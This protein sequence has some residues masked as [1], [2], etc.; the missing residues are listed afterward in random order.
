MD[1]ARCAARGR[2]AR[3]LRPPA[4]PRSARTAATR[5]HCRAGTRGP[6]EYGEMRRVRLRPH[7]R[8]SPM[9]AHENLRAAQRLVG[10]VVPNPTFDDRRTCCEHRRSPFRHQAP[11]H[12]H[13]PPRWTGGDRAEHR[14]R[15]HHLD[16]GHER[17]SSAR[18]VGQIRSCPSAWSRRHWHRYRRLSRIRGMRYSSANSS[19]K[20]PRPPLERC[21]GNSAEP[22][23]GR[24]VLAA[25]GDGATVDLADAHHTGRRQEANQLPVLILAQSGQCADL[26]ERSVVKQCVDALANGQSPRSMLTLDL[27]GRADLIRQRDSPTQFFDSGSQTMPR[28]RPV[29]ARLETVSYDGLSL[30]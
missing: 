3:R 11:V 25:D 6:P 24:E 23:P 15:L 20:P 1:A 10:H 19:R 30:R 14:Y 28:S 9:C 8:Y 4:H 21:I 5:S 13:R 22:L 26:V 17:S 7:Y 12:H 18:A 16:R 2:S 27:V 29:Q